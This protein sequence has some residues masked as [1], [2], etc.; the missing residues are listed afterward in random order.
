MSWPNTMEEV[1]KLK[2]FKNILYAY[3]GDFSQ[4]VDKLFAE[5]LSNKKAEIVKEWYEH[6]TRSNKNFGDTERELFDKHWEKIKKLEEIKINQ[7]Y[8]SY[9]DILE[10]AHRQNAD[11]FPLRKKWDHF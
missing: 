3:S 8:Q 5:E 6:Y 10:K 11:L 7:E 1:G 2:N 4:K 9:I